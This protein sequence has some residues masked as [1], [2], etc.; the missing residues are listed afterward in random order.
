MQV[1]NNVAT[2][3]SNYNLDWEKYLGEDYAK[4]KDKID[5]ALDRIYE[6]LAAN[7]VDAKMA[8]AF[9]T[10]VETYAYK[11]IVHGYNLDKAV[12]EIKEINPEVL[13]VVVGAYNPLCNTT[14][15]YEGKVI[16]LGEYVNYLFKAFRANDL[17]Y[18]IITAD[19]TYVD[20]PAVE[21]MLN[22]T[23][24]STEMLA[25]IT[26]TKLLPT[27][28][29]HKYIQEQI[30]NALNITRNDTPLPPPP[31]G[32]ITASVAVLTVLLGTGIVALVSKRKSFI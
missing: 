31:T 8:E 4:I 7:G 15:E 1:V 5:A 14:Y 18:A 28:A 13:I 24:L 9:V 32:D 2:S 29:G 26:A 30:Y 17:A 12:A 25:K 21:I 19:V 22:E 27:D 11:Y 16:D 3:G 6:E 10:A 23:E 20:A